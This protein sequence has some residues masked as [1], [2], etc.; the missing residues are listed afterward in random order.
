M[1]IEICSNNL[2]WS[3]EVQTYSNQQKTL[4]D[5]E[6]VAS[7]QQNV[8]WQQYYHPFKGTESVVNSDQHPAKESKSPK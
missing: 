7:H 4:R 5:I 1:W 3:Y 8:Y 6:Y 2:F